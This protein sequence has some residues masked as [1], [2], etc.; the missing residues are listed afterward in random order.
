MSTSAQHTNSSQRQAVVQTRCVR[1]KTSWTDATW[2]PVEFSV[3]L[4]ERWEAASRVAWRSNGVQSRAPRQLRPPGQTGD[5]EAFQL[6]PQPRQ[7]GL[8][9]RTVRCATRWGSPSRAHRALCRRRFPVSIPSSVAATGPA[10]NASALP[11]PETAKT[12]NPAA[13]E[14]Q[15]RREQPFGHLSTRTENR[16]ARREPPVGSFREPVVLIYLR[17]S[18][19]TPPGRKRRSEV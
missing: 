4:S 11:A 3:H 10:W 1:H 6:P 7:S 18:R 19:A 5:E 2:N 14:G 15:H 17:P 9:W 13:S 8:R 12:A 16:T